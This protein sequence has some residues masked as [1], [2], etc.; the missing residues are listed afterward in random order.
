MKI[1]KIFFISTK[2]PHNFMYVWILLSIKLPQKARFIVGRNFYN[3][4]IKLRIIE[5]SFYACGIKDA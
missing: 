3:T 1:V 4:Y 2:P 5:K